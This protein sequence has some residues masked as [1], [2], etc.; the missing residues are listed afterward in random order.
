MLLNNNENLRKSN[1]IEL[2]TVKQHQ[3][4]INKW[5]QGNIEIYNWPRNELGYG[6]NPLG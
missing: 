2:D 3:K 4:I 5:Y 1:K 6:K